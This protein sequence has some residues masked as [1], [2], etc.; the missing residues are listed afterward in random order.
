MNRV[1]CDINPVQA[2][3][4]LHRYVNRQRMK[5]GNGNIHVRIFVNQPIRLYHDIFISSMNGYQSVGRRNGVRRDMNAFGLLIL[6]K[7]V[8]LA[9]QLKGDKRT[10]PDKKDQDNQKKKYYFFHSASVADF[11]RLDK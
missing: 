8:G 2:M 3:A 5:Q 9:G 7:P 6:D 4:A 10:I 11:E 1:G